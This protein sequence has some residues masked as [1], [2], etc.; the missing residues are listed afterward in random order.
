MELKQKQLQHLENGRRRGWIVYLLFSARP[1]PLSFNMLIE[2]LDARNMPLTCRRFSEKLDYLR[3]A[4]FVR[5]FRMGENREL[6]NVE[7]A[8]LIQAYCDN[9]GEGADGYFASL[10]TK[11]VN[12]QE[13]HL[14]DP[15]VARVN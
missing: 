1:S 6:S 5:V 3:S 4:G 2:L 9:D 13:G 10:S 8:Q 7:Q 11:G 14:N 12:F 15:G